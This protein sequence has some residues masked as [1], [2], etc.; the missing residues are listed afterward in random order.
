MILP[1][2]S[3]WQVTSRARTFEK[4]FA[5]ACCVSRRGLVN[6]LRRLGL[7][8]HRSEILHKISNVRCIEISQTVG[9]R[10]SHRACGGAPPIGMTH[11]QVIGDLAIG[12]AS[13]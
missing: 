10:L 3:V 2:A 13:Q 1:S 6:D 11:L 5:Q 4:P 9:H 12:P 8:A 7:W